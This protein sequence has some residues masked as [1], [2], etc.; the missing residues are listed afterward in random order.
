[1]GLDYT[2]G[3]DPSA[4]KKLLHARV[5]AEQEIERLRYLA[6]ETGMRLLEKNAAETWYGSKSKRSNLD[7]VVASDN[8][9]FRSFGGAEV[10]V[11]GW[12]K[13]PAN[14][15]A[16]WGKRYSDHALLYFEVQ[17]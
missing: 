9:S 1:M 10:D 2:Y 11:R 16:A 7:H 14:E 15:Q 13:L 17:R 8:V 12:P 4:P 3:R 5:P 6:G